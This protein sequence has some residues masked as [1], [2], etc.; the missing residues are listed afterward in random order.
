LSDYLKAELERYAAAYVQLY[1]EE[2][3][4]AVALIPHMLEAFMERDR[5]FRKVAATMNRSGFS[6]HLES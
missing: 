3:I 4:D 5:V 2:P 1:G 6:D